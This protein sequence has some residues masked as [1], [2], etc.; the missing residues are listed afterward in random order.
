MRE[1][2]IGKSA[3]KVGVFPCAALGLDGDMFPA[4]NAATGK[5]RARKRGH[6]T[7]H[8]FYRTNLGHHALNRI[9]PGLVV[10]AIGHQQ[11]LS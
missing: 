7:N 3:T 6:V 2:A 10:P 11:L 8:M 4:M 9:Q 1:L 5:N